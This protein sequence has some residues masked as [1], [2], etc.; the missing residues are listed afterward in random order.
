MQE[1]ILDT[2]ILVLH[3]RQSR[4]RSLANKTVADAE[5]W[6]IKL[7]KIHQTNAILTPIYLEFIG[8][9]VDRHEM[10]LSKAFLGQFQIIDKGK[11]TPKDWD[12]ARQLAE[13]IPRGPKPTPRGAVDCLIKAIARRLRSELMTFDKGMPR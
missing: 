1:I 13:R 5:K 2:N 4:G 3:W 12:L 6:A 11:I 9:V 8:G 10:E 7:I